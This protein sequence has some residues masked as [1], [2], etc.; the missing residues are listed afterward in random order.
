MR[1]HCGKSDDQYDPKSS[2]AG[3]SCK[4]AIVEVLAFQFVG[5]AAE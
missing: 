2:I 5:L 3:K 1:R 4:S